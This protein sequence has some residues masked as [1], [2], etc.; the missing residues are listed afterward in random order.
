MDL[1]LK[2]INEMLYD[3]KEIYIV[4]RYDKDELDKYYF[5]YLVT[6]NINNIETQFV[7]F[8]INIIDNAN[9][10]LVKEVLHYIKYN[11]TSIIKNREIKPFDGLIKN[12]S[13]HTETMIL[14]A[15]LGNI[16]NV[17]NRVHLNN[18]LYTKSFVLSI[19]FFSIYHHI[20]K[21][22]QICSRVLKI[23]SIIKKYWEHTYYKFTCNL[24]NLKYTHSLYFITYVNL[25]NTKINILVHD[26]TLMHNIFVLYRQCNNI[27]NVNIFTKIKNWF[28]LKTTS[29]EPI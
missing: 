28:K 16:F 6:E 5:K 23:D 10:L 12:I 4:K 25:F 15:E 14:L 2:N 7:K 3:F 8:T 26:I 17:D 22:K 19:I 21:T 20:K 1:V 13:I 18:L 27:R 9:I 11:M 24:K 29:Y